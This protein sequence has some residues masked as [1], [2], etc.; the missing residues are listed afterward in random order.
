MFD[1][2]YYASILHYENRPDVIVT[3]MLFDSE[4]DAL[5]HVESMKERDPEILPG[6][7]AKVWGKP[8]RRVCRVRVTELDEDE[9]AYNNTDPLF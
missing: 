8:V 2:I 6:P 3:P 5:N 1:R 7:I 9:N 4:R